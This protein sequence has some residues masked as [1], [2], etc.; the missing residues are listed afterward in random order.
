[1]IDT[2]ELTRQHKILLDYQEKIKPFTATVREIGKLWGLSST[3]SV[4]YRLQN[5]TKRGWVIVHEVD[6]SSKDMNR[7]YYAIPRKEE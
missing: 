1:M 5:M 2:P 7:K 3:S 4:H 6:A